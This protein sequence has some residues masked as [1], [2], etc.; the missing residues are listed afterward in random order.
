M[1]LNLTKELSLINKFIF[2]FVKESID[3]VLF[4]ASNKTFFDR[5]SFITNVNRFFSIIQK[6]SINLQIDC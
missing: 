3:L 5:K 6:S 1:Q 2:K 4:R